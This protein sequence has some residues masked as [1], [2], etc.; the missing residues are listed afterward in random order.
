MDRRAY[1]DRVTPARPELYIESKTKSMTLCAL[2]PDPRASTRRVQSSNP[3]T[4][5]RPKVCTRG[6][7]TRPTDGEATPPHPVHN[8]A[9]KHNTQGWCGYTNHVARARL[10]G[11]LRAAPHATGVLTGTPTAH[12][13]VVGAEREDRSERGC[14]PWSVTTDIWEYSCVR[15]DALRV[16]TVCAVSRSTSRS[17][18]HW[19][20]HL[21]RR[22]P[23]STPAF[24]SPRRARRAAPILQRC[25]HVRRR[26]CLFASRR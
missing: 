4:R 12:M 11:A 2:R 14:C 5:G 25:P 22:S 9:I 19:R 7:A 24:R 8:K 16:V 1:R 23:A 13:Q 18:P 26:A 17:W 3:F 20:P 21:L 10:R 15:Y 6:R